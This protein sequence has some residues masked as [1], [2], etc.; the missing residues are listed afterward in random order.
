MPRTEHKARLQEIRLVV[1]GRTPVTLPD[2]P[3]AALSTSMG[4]GGHNVAL[5]FADAS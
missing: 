3:L 5:A 4:F 1:V 2:G